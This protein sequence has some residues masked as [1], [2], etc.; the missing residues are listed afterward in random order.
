MHLQFLDQIFLIFIIIS[1]RLTPSYMF[2]IFIQTSL[3]PYIIN[4]PDGLTVR[5]GAKHDQCHEHWWSNLLYINNI[6]PWKM[7]E[8][9]Y[10]M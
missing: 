2:A 8:E 10:S 3:Y 7:A 4:S 9:V 6:Y 5:A 1:Y